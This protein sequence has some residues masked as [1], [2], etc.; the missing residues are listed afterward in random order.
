MPSG[1]LSRRQQCSEPLIEQF[2]AWHLGLAHRNQAD[3][4]KRHTKDHSRTFQARPDPRLDLDNP[5]KAADALSNQ[6]FGSAR[7]EVR[8]DVLAQRFAWGIE[9]HT[10][11]PIEPGKPAQ[12]LNA[13]FI[14][15]A[16]DERA[17]VKRWAA[18][19]SDIGLHRVR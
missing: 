7:T 12:V 16:A 2:I 15:W 9:R 18:V 17:I 3:T 8:R 5:S 14:R 10:V 13:D 6:R 19:M 11:P 1:S 4:A